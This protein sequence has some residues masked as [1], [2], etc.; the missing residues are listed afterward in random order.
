[1]RFAEDAIMMATQERA[2]TSSLEISGFNTAKGFRPHLADLYDKAMP[3]GICFKARRLLYATS[4]V[5][6]RDT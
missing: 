2:K 6:V 3:T 4:L 5:I 1:M